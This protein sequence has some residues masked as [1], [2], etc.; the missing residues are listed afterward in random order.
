MTLKGEF[1]RMIQEEQTSGN[2]TDDEAAEI[3]KTG[4]ML[5]AGE[6]VLK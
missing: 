3:I 2:L 5:L 1:V 4:I 6:E